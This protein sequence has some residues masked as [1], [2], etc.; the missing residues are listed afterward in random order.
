LYAKRLLL[1]SFFAVVAVA[2]SDDPDTNNNALTDTGAD[3]TSDA[4]GDADPDATEPLGARVRFEPMAEDF[5]SVPLPSDTRIKADGTFGFGD[6]DRAYESQLLRLWLNAADDLLE[7][8]GLVS[9]IYVH[10]TAPIDVSTLPQTIAETATSQGLPSSV[11]LV[12]VDPES[13]QQGEALPIDCKF[14]EAEG[15]YHDANL[16]S[17][18]SPFG[19]VRRPNTRYA[20]VVTS[21]VTDAEGEPLVADAAMA[22]LLAG[23]DVEGVNGT[24]DAAPYVAAKE[25]L[26]DAGVGALGARRIASLTLFTTGDPASRLVRLNDWFRE[27][28]EPQVDEDSLTFVEE[29]DDYVVLR[30]TYQAPIIQ[31][32]DRPYSRPPD[33]K[34]VFD[35][36]G[37]PVEQAKSTIPFLVTVPKTAQPDGGWPVLLYMHGSGGEMQE[38]IDRGARPELEVAAPRGTGPGG[39]VAPYGI[40]GFAAEFGFHG[41]RFSPPD[42]TG[43]KLYDLLNNPRATVDNFLVS[44]NE[45]TLHARFLKGLTIDP[46]VANGLIDAGDAADGLVRFNTDSFTA[47]GQSMG[48]T[49]GLPAL[50][51]SEEVDAGILSGSGGTLIEVALES[52]KPMTLKPIL[53]QVLSYRPD[54][55]MDRY[56]PILSSLQQVWDYVDPIVHARHA[57]HEVHPNTPAK[58]ILQH[59]GIDDGYFSVES[60]TALSAALGIDFAEPVD[61]TEALDIMSIAAPE[62]DQALALPVTAN[63]DGTHTGVV[64]M[65]QPSVMDGHNVAYQRDD[66]KAQYACF[67]KTVGS[68]GAPV[69]KSVED[70]QVGACE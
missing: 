53:R 23:E 3:A 49:I 58:H 63:I 4:T 60:R 38:L 41:T 37:D 39:V 43:L 24:I 55:A 56:D 34:V 44:A 42:T 18:I 8:W 1:A 20:F 31:A 45:V 7:G 21:A 51:V 33:G 14:T 62:H 46:A 67:V 26:M 28:P 5:F 25:F 19:V 68:G 40:A 2:C 61:E 59:S 10:T 32:G 66:A 52:T 54:E 30:G 47:M 64:G 11:L 22:K 70:A 17:C 15:T 16:L 6:W 27:L 50:T 69:F 35:E 57:I 65:Y 13:P 48:S 9:G 29:F 12:D 36:A